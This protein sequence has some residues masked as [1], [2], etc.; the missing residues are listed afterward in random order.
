[1]ANRQQLEIGK[2]FVDSLRLERSTAFEERFLV[3]EV[4]HMWTPARDDDRVG[5]QI[6][7]SFD[8]IA[9]NRRN[10]R[11]RAHLRAVQARRG[12]APEV[13]EKLRPGVLAWAQK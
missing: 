10:G 1:M 9:A 3:T 2:S 7:P 8:Q 5:H 6:K 4:A 11:Q 12:T 13:C